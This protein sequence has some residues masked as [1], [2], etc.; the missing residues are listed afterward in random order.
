MILPL[1]FNFYIIFY[2]N[3]IISMLGLSH[4]IIHYLIT[5]FYICDDIQTSKVDL[6]NRIYQIMIINILKN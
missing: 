3:I 5:I 1:K 6:I 4:G 2:V